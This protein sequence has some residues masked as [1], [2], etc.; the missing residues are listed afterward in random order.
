[1]K[2]RPIL[3]SAP[4]IKSILAGE[5]TQTRRVV[6]K[7]FEIPCITGDCSH[8]KQDECDD[9]LRAQCPYGNIGDQLWV[10]ETF[11]FIYPNEFP[12]PQKECRV[13]Y[14]A[15]TNG[16][17]LPGQ[18][19]DEERDHDDCPKW[20]PSIHM[21]RFASRINLRIVNIFIES[22]QDISEEDA[23]FE[24]CPNDT[25]RNPKQWFE[26]IWMGINGEKSWSEDPWVWVIEFERIK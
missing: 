7:P 2:E 4:M 16:S 9:F 14:R 5:K 17:C 15:D 1:M 6:K 21:P 23:R 26:D 13:E 11:A 19:P 8:E 3:F 12:V 24:G 20:K 22:L 18:W 25:W 10:R